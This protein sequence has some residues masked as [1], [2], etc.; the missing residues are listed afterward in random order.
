MTKLATWGAIVASG[1][2]GAAFIVALV[3]AYLSKDQANLPLLIGSVISNFSTVVSFWVGSSAGSQKKD[4][5]L[6]S[7]PK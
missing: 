6:G 5:M 3:I 2:A 7:Q 4:E 1:I